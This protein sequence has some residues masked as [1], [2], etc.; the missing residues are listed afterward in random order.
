M[1]DT[2]FILTDYQQQLRYINLNF[3]F[4]D[5]FFQL[6]PNTFVLAITVDGM[7]QV[8]YS[9]DNLGSI[10]IAEMAKALVNGLAP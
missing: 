6:H 3:Q 1:R 9:E 4:R 10:A 2:F 8:D 7:K 5:T